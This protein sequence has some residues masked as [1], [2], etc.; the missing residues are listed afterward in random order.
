MGDFKVGD[1]ITG[2]KEN[3]RYAIT[4]SDSVCVVIDV[5]RYSNGMFVRAL[6]N[7]WHK[8]DEKS[9]RDFYVQ[10]DKEL[11]KVLMEAR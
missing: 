1:I 11:F 8:F 3:S 2:T 9:N 5:S 6:Y 7:R 4:N 10:A